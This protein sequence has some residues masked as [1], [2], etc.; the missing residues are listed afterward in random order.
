MGRIEK[1]KEG[2][3]PYKK[4]PNNRDTPPSVVY[5][6]ICKKKDCVADWGGEKPPLLS[7]SDSGSLDAG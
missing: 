2:E 4:V 1:R 3:L 6:Y 5:I 7:V